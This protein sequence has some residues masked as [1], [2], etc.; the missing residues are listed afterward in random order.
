MTAEEWLGVMQKASDF[1]R[2]TEKLIRKYG[3]MIVS[4]HRLAIT[5]MKCD[6]NK[7]YSDCQI[8]RG[9]STGCLDCS[10]FKLIANSLFP[11]GSFDCKDP[12][13]KAYQGCDY[14]K[15]KTQ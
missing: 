6:E 7:A 11:C 5:R 8:H 1:P 15:Y 4:E 3:E 10:S 2:G 12:H 14:C 13:E 9:I